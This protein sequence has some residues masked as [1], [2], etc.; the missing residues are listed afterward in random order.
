VVLVD[1]D[2]ILEELH[3]EL[4]ATRSGAGRIALLTGE[5]GI[6][7]SAVVNAFRSAHERAVSVVVGRCDPLSV[8][9]TMGPI[10]DVADA[11]GLEVAPGVAG[12]SEEA[13]ELLKALQ[14]RHRVIVIE[15]A[16]W[17]DG[18]TLDF[19]V[20]AWRRLA[21]GPTLW[22]VTYRSDEVAAGHPLRVVLGRTA[23]AHP[24]HIVVRPLTEVA[25]ARLAEGTDLDP[26]ELTRVTG[27]NPFYVTEA[28]AAGLEPVPATVVDSVLARAATVSEQARQALDSACV[29]PEGVR[30][31]IL[32]GI[33][34]GTEGIDE[35]L[36]AGLLEDRAGRLVFR[37]E[38]ARRA[39]WQELP[40]RGRRQLHRRALT[41]L[42][43]EAASAGEA[44]RRPP[45]PAEM[46]FH[47]VESD[48][49]SAITSYGLRAAEEAFAAS[50]NRAAAQHLRDVLQRGARLDPAR[51]A[52]TLDRL[53]LAA[54]NSGNAAD[55]IDAHRLAAQ[56][57]ESAGE[58][59]L[60]AQ[61]RVSLAVQLWTSG[62]GPEGR[63]MMDSAVRALEEIGGPSLASAYA[64]QA[65]L[66]MLQRDVQG[67]LEA[68]SRAVALAEPLDDKES[69]SRAYNAIGTSLWFV[70]PDEAEPALELSLKFGRAAGSPRLVA[71]ALVNL[72]SGA[73]EIRR[74]DVAERWLDETV[75][76]CTDHDLDGYGDYGT[77]W[78][79]RV[80]LE[81]GRWSE[82]ADLAHRVLDVPSTAIVS[83]VGSTVLGLVRARRGDSDTEHL[84]EQ[85]WSLAVSTGDLQ[86][87]WPVAA[88][89][90]EASWW[91]HQRVD[92]AAL[93][94]VET[95][96]E[97]AV[98][99]KHP[100][101]VGELARWIAH[102]DPGRPP[103]DGAA[104]PFAL[105]L[106][107]DFHAAAESWDEIGCPFDA[108]LALLET[109]EE[110]AVRQCLDV[111]DELGA[112][113]AARLARAEL[114]RL[115]ARNI[116]R[117]PRAATSADPAGLTPREVEV[118][119][120]LHR[121]LSN[122]AIAETLVISPRTVDRHVSS[123]LA[124]LGVASR[125]D[126]AVL[127]EERLAAANMGDAPANL[128]VPNA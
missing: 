40:E 22:L 43:Q 11:L 74:Y 6:G 41:V 124:K 59:A 93:S 46:A 97:M 25:V 50:A 65:A 105:E 118:L 55:A 44:G 122:T 63:A 110:D 94:R 120:L 18:A 57:W 10:R 82:A 70:R 91:Q 26:A 111:F 107:G 116:P 24:R 52:Q 126:A 27:G 51:R 9:R 56:T 49:S 30:Y 112:T 99:I 79:A 119:S 1:R 123:L 104:E 77:C 69:L 121:R 31:D 32:A 90:A 12:G 7:K 14:S 102:A 45:D 81:R 20:F 16:H 21:S 113:P 4:E 33:A 95:A 75:A 78:K 53:G 5:A 28:I 36:R 89:C 8:P 72:G 35:C 71:G 62:Q 128:G 42:E 39:I 114:R 15:D 87:L 108:A 106:R 34:H 109:E 60:A 58:P 80:A 17:A 37:H 2:G 47:A 54:S 84:L 88:A 85:A 64:Q 19:L 13:A 125:H 86:R 66:R 103:P 92:D 83:L 117:G 101:A 98:A 38:L 115:G 73:G 96:M 127:W 76:W 100:W 48:A 3:R 61:S 23:T 29:F 68:G 67:A